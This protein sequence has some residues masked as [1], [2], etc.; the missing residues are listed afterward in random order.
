M[1]YARSGKKC[2]V[3]AQFWEAVGSK[4]SHMTIDYQCQVV[5]KQNAKKVE[6][7]VLGVFSVLENCQGIFKIPCVHLLSLGTP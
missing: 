4:T 2:A 3:F 7:L 6:K 1:V 5:Q